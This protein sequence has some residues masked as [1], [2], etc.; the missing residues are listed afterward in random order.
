MVMTMMTMLLIMMMLLVMRT[1]MMMMKFLWRNLRGSI[2][3]PLS[4]QRVPDGLL[5][6]MT[7]LVIIFTIIFTIDFLPMMTLFVIFFTI[8]FF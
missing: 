2:I 1:T 8:D 3:A 6:M 5:P 4:A 7:L